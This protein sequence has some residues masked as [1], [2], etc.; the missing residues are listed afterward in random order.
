MVCSS[1]CRIPFTAVLLLRSGELW[2]FGFPGLRQTDTASYLG[3]VA[4]R[5]RSRPRATSFS[6][7]FAGS[8]SEHEHEY[9]SV[10]VKLSS[11]RGLGRGERVSR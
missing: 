5:P 8:V 2:W 7:G 10:G 11:R 9:A 1:L 4:F 6:V 3:P